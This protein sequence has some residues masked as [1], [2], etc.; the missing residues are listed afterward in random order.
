MM[1]PETQKSHNK[2]I[3]SLFYHNYMQGKGLDIGYKGEYADRATP[4]LDAIGVDLDFPGYDGFRLP[5]AD[6]SQDFVFASHVLEH[7]EHP[8]GMIRDWFRT[9]KIGGYLVIC[10]PHRDLYEKKSTLPSKW[11]GDH[12]RFYTPKVLIVQ[13]E[14]ALPTPNTWRLRHMRDNDD[15]FDYS[16]PP[17]R[18]SSGAYEIE[19]VI[20][21]IQPP[22]WEVK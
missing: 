15:G 20:Q 14:V 8:L 18:H 6:G 4:V 10:V 19:C 22:N 21:K 3:D 5:F 7:V 11:N 13:I 12:K 16:I 17:H 9:L 2:R 1:G